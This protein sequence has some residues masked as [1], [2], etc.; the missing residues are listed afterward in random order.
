MTDSGICSGIG[1]KGKPMKGKRQKDKGRKGKRIV[2]LL[3][4]VLL[5]LGTA[6]GIGLMR[7]GRGSGNASAPGKRPGGGVALVIDPDAESGL[8]YQDEAV[9]EQGVVIA[10]RDSMTIAA[11][12]KKVKADF[13]N[14]EENAK[15]YYL[16]FELRLCGNGSQDYEVLY[17]SGLVE[18]GKRIDRITL[19]RELEQGVYEAVVHVQPY[20]MN[21]ERTPT[22]N[23]DMRIKLI[24]G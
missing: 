7:H 11:D 13:R 16:T 8:S 1:Q 23:I 19:S 9:L 10:G 4:L 15:L 18:P 21:E 5:L 12:T 3:L 6:A 17:T 24:V 20:C 2:F 14:P 22:N